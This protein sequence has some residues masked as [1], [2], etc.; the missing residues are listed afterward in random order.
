MI[1]A[2]APDPALQDKQQEDRPR[3]VRRPD[4]PVPP[5]KQR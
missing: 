1:H 3:L 2:L 5:P 4:G